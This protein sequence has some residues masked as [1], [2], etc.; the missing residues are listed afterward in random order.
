MHQSQYQDVV[1]D[2]QDNVF[3][4]ASLLE[5]PDPDGCSSA[6]SAVI[7]RPAADCPKNAKRPRSSGIFGRGP[8]HL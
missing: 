5:R 6:S 4:N 3:R 1:T 7:Q 8:K 2:V